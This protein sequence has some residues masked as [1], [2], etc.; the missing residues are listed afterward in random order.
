MAGNPN[1]WSMQYP[2]SLSQTL[3]PPNPPPHHQT[4]VLAG[5]SSLPAALNHSFPP[6]H[7]QDPPHYS[8]SHLLLGSSNTTSTTGLSGDEKKFGNSSSSNTLSH[9]LFQPSKLEN[10]EEDQILNGNNPAA[11]HPEA[12]TADHNQHH[13]HDVIKDEV[14][15]KNNLL[16]GDQGREE[17]YFQ[18]IN[19]SSNVWSQQVVMPVSSPKSCVTSNTSLSSN[20]MLDFSYNNK[21][22]GNG[23][24]QNTDHSSEC[25]STATGGVV[26]KRARVQPPSSQPPLKVRKEKLG[27][28]ITALHQLV[29]PFGKTDT[30]SVLLEAIGYVRFLQSQIEALSSPYLGHASKNMRNKQQYVDGQGDDHEKPKDLKSRGLCLV[31]VSCTQHVGSDNGADYWAPASYGSGF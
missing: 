2:P 31:P 29:S 28:R 1:W 11:R 30:A 16:Y 23:R 4:Y 8:W 9:H 18:A 14:S 21:P 13:H 26:S 19:R 7:A 6:D 25:N 17:E 27:D 12:T 20:N 24:N 22:D 3:F 5:S 10:W 15:L